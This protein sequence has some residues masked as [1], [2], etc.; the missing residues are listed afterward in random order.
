MNSLSIYTKLRNR[1][2]G[3]VVAV[4]IGN[5]K[6]SDD[7]I[8]VHLVRRLRSNDFLKTILVYDSPEFYLS[9]II[10]EA[11][12][13]IMFVDSTDLKSPP[14]SFAL[15]E[16]YQLCEVW[17]HTHRVPLTIIV[18]YISERTDA[19]IFLLGIQ[20]VEISPGNRLKPSTAKTV[21]MLADFINTGKNRMMFISL[22]MA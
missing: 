21:K 1:F 8:G 13:V 10:S 11:P 2:Y 6:S 20:P 3:K 12:D 4:G 5:T 17:G 9:E 15:I 22:P 14:G 7:G 16:E 18:K 19:D